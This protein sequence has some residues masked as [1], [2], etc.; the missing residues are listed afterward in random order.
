VSDHA[1]IEL[2]A[3]VHAGAIRFRAVPAVHTQVAEFPDG[4]HE[5]RSTRTNLPDRVEQG[6][7]YRNAG[8][9][10]WVRQWIRYGK[11]NS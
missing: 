10:G 6:R 9:T 4:M 8:V 5:S 1:D 11:A 7:I 2:A 3:Q